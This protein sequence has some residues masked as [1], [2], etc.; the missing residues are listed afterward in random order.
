MKCSVFWE[1]T[2]CSPLKINLRFRGTLRFHLFRVEEEAKQGKTGFL[3]DLFF[4]A[5]PWK[6]GVPPKRR[7][8][9]SGR[10]G[11]ISQ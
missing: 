7:S 4:D 1:V 3:L 8:T 2:S 9:F 11:N 5:E 6:R 10:P